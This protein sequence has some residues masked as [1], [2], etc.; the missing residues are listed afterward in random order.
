MKKILLSAAVCFLAAAGCADPYAGY[1]LGP[2]RDVVAGSVDA[3]GGIARCRSVGNIEATAVV[4]IYDD[5]GKATINE[6]HQVINPEGD[7]IRASAK[8]A[9][10]SWT[11]SVGGIGGSRF[12]SKGFVASP[13]RKKAVI[14]SLQTILHRVRGPRN[15]CGGDEK[16]TATERVRIDGRDLIR[17][18]VT[19][20]VGDIKAYYFDAQTSVLRMVTAG[21][22]EA[23]GDGTVTVY[24]WQ[25]FPNG[26]AFPVRI[27]VMK[28][29]SNVLVGDEPVLEVDYLQVKW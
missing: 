26:M 25:M 16:P 10:G 2:A 5:A 19:G 9:D 21:S 27:S 28:I 11:A 13:E 29:G 24:S 22:D 6:Q 15:L 14:E 23:G 3:M 4:S 12:K 7:V 1:K 18:P 17:V 20:G 8:T